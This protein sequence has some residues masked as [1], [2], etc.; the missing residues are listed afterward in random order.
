MRCSAVHT[1]VLFIGGTE[2]KNEAKAHETPRTHRRIPVDIARSIIRVPLPSCV[3]PL[4]PRSISFL[5]L[6]CLCDDKLIY[7]SLQSDSSSSNASSGSNAGWGWESSL[8]GAG[9][10]KESATKWEQSKQKGEMGYYFAH[11]TSMK[12]LAPEDYRMNGP[13]L[14]SK[15]P[16]APQASKSL[17]WFI[18]TPFHCFSSAKGYLTPCVVVLVS[19][20]WPR[21]RGSRQRHIFAF[22]QQGFSQGSSRQC[23]CGRQTAVKNTAR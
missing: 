11:H 1:T 2:R 19:M 7:T 16:T 3:S 18:R 5:T 17:H 8:F 12:E 4:L 14:L 21:T 15:G 23:Y 13:R 20:P 10:G 9:G 6:S 22:W